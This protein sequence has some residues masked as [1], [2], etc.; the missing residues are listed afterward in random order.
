MDSSSLAGG[1]MYLLRYFG[2]GA[3]LGLTTTLDL[4]NQLGLGIFAQVP[5]VGL[6]TIAESE[7]YY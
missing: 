5:R 1:L 6:T 7:S 2:L 4:G 3:W